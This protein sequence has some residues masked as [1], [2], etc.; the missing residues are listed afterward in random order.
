[1][2][3]LYFIALE[4]ISKLDKSKDNIIRFPKVF[5][6]LCSTFCITK[7]D[8]WEVLL[9]FRDIGFIEIVP[10]QGIKMKI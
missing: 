1:M 3:G 8:C 10:Y 7:K 6:K 4:R 5:E 9:T 2:T